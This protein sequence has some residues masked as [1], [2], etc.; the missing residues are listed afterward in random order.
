MSQNEKLNLSDGEFGVTSPNILLSRKRASIF[1]ELQSDILRLQG[2]KS[3]SNSLLDAGLG[4]IAESFPN[5]S[6]PLGAVHVTGS[7]LVPV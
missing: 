5:A 1:T 3:S 2:L 7:S 6:F 4:P